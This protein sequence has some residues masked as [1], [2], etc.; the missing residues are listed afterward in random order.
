MFIVTPETVL[1]RSALEMRQVPRKFLGRVTLWP[2]RGG[3]GLWLR[4][5]L[6]VEIWRYLLA[7]V[8]FAVA[9]FV[10]PDYAIAIAQAPLPM[11]I[12]VYFVESRLLR[13]PK[14]RRLALMERAEIERGLDLLR[15]RSVRILTRIAAGRGMTAGTLHLVIEQSDMWRAPPLTYVSVQSATGPEILRLSPDERR[16]I[17]ESLFQP[18]LTETDLLRLNL[19]DGTHLRDIAFETGRVS[20]HS[21][22][23]ALMGQRED[24]A[25]GGLG[26]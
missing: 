5:F 25:I 11:L 17:G 7:L 13:L 18:P 26:G 24:M 19:A 8:P 20:A 1:N 12:L 10:W 6:E 15:A 16:Q 21:R 2:A 9:A 22:L 3:A 4:V 23:A 14:A